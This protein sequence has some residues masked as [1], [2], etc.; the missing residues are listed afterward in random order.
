MMARKGG[1]KME[2]ADVVKVVE[3]GDFKK[4]NQYLDLGWKLLTIYKT[5]YDNQTPGINYQYPHYVLGW[6]DG[7]PNYPEEPPYK[8]MPG[9]TYV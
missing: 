8:P 2:F 9:G 7:E 3:L 1:D 4:V 6:T 5:A